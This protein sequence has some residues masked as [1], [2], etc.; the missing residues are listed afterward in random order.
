M[1]RLAAIVEFSGEANISIG[2]DGL[3]TSW[4]PAAE[5]MYG[6]SSDEMIG[7]PGGFVVPNQDP[8]DGPAC[9]PEGVRSGPTIRA[10]QSRDHRHTGR[11]GYLPRPAPVRSA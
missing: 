2:P 10:S 3:I 9:P 6:Y 7:K 11:R 8:A 1:S 4:N 5:R